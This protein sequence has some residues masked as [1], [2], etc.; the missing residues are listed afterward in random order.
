LHHYAW[1]KRP[2]IIQVHDAW[3]KGPTIIQVHGIGPF[4]FTHVNPADDPRNK[5]KIEAE[6][7]A[8]R[9]TGVSAVQIEKPKPGRIDH[10]A[11]RGL[12][13]LRCGRRG[14]FSTAC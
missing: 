1:A 4:A 14:L 12:V 13:S 11:R 8:S 6:I 3:A 9:R 10:G 5:H 7:I 2:T